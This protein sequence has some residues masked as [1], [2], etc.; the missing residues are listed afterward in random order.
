MLL[1]TLA[2]CSPFGSG[3]DRDEQAIAVVESAVSAAV[4]EAN[5]VFVTMAF[6]GPANR[7]MRVRLYI[8][9]V[10]DAALADA[11][12]RAAREA[13]ATSPIAVISI[14]LEAVAGERPEIPPR[15]VGQVISLRSVAEQLG[16]D[17]RRVVSGRLAL[18]ETTLV[19]LYGPAGVDAE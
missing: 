16:I 13:W 8:D 5:G 18:P 11:V 14:S 17:E 19:R 12:D 4:P 9:P 1:L 3:P 10:D 15:G 7:T 6:S 2:A